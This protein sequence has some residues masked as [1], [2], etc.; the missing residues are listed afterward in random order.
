MDDKDYE[1]LINSIQDT[2]NAHKKIGDNVGKMNEELEE[3][4]KI[5]DLVEKRK[6]I[7]EFLES[8][9]NKNTDTRKQHF[10]QMYSNKKL[11]NS[12]QAK[13]NELKQKITEHKHTSDTT[14]RRVAKE[15]YE[16]KKYEYYKNM[17]RVLIIVQLFVILII[18]GNISGMFT[19]NYTFIIIGIILVAVVCYLLYYVYFNNY[20]RD[21]FD[22]DKIYFGD[23]SDTSAEC[24]VP[25]TQEEKDIEN[26]KKVADEKIKEIIKEQS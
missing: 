2:I 15:K 17:Y 18:I 26:M 20:N 4:S 24:V 14:K 16:K 21:K 12:Q 25:P 3:Y 1:K 5:N 22:W 13:I 11:I 10:D 9:Y 7:F 19:K 6:K 8:K 23:P